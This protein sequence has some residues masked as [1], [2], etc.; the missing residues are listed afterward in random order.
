M[1]FWS[2]H[3]LLQSSVTLEEIDNADD[4]VAKLEK[5]EPPGQM[6]SFLTEPLLQKFVHLKPSPVT[7]SRIDLWLATYLEEEYNA[8]RSGLEASSD[9]TSFLQ[10]LYEH[11]Q[12]TK[13]CNL[14]PFSTT[15]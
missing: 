12:F 4:F 5:I 9:L 14:G 10:S 6:V 11:T 1:A 7:D 15:R 3:A 8:A 13:V 2:T